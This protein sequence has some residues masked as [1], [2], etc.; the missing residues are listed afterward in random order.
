MSYI[1]SIYIVY[2]NMANVVLLVSAMKKFL[3]Q[4]FNLDF[5]GTLRRAQCI[6]I[7][8]ESST[9]PMFLMKTKYG[10]QFWLS[11]RELKDHEIT[12]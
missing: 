3:N 7:E 4:W 9:G 12:N 10:N 8:F 1:Y 6:D 11:R 5:N 2:N